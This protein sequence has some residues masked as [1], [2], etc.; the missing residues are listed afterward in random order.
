M[1]VEH[2]DFRNHRVNHLDGVADRPACAVGHEVR[3]EGQLEDDH[4]FAMNVALLDA[5]L[6]ILAVDFLD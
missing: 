5:D 6:D 2:V 3:R 1:D 4:R